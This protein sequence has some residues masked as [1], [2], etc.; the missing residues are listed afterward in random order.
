MH[1]NILDSPIQ[2][3]KGVGPKRGDLLKKELGIHTYYHLLTFFPFRYVDR[4]RIFTISELHSE[5]PLIQLKGKIISLAMLGKPRQKR[6]VAKFQ[7]E[8]GIIELVWFRGARWFEKLLNKNEEYLVFGK[9]NVYNGKLSMSHPEIDLL[10]EAD[11]AI[12]SPLQAVYSSTER[13]SSHGLNS[14]GIGKLMKELLTVSK[15]F[16][17][18]VLPIEMLQKNGL[19]PREESFEHVHI[20]GNSELLKKATYRLKF[21]ELFFI[22]LRILQSRQNRITSFKG[23]NFSQVGEHFNKFYKDVLPFELTKA[24]KRVIKEIRA[25]VGSGNQ[26]NR[27]LQGDVGS[28][29]TIVAFMVMLI[30]IDNGF[31]ACIMAPTAI[32]ANQHFVSIG[33]LAEKLELKIALLTGASTASVRKKLHEELE[34][35]DLHILI[36]THALIEDKV[37]FKNLGFV[38]IDEQHRFGVAQ[39][40]RLWK[41]NPISP[42]HILVM[43]ATPIPRT[44][45]MTLY[46]ELDVSIIDELP[47]GRM[48]VKTVHRFDK[49]RLSVFSFIK[50]QIKEGRQVYIVYPLIQESEK[51]D[52][53]DLMDGYESISR[54]FPR[55]EFQLCIV[56]GQMKPADKDFEMQRFVNGEAQIMVATNVIEVGV[57]IPNA[58]VMIIESAERFGLSQ[59]HQLRGR[60]GRGAKQSYCILMTG[61]K[62]SNDGKLRMNTLVRTNDGFEIA[63]VD[64]KLRGPGDLEGTQQSG[65]LDLKIADL[66]RDVQV[67]HQAREQASALLARDPNLATTESERVAKHLEDRYRHVKDWSR[68]S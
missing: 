13:L 22:Q 39:R 60:V 2:F 56:H 26:M 3:L 32:L 12:K 33:E 31:Q 49:S 62:L 52:Y 20:P 10:A 24:Q 46:G 37:K 29:K 5:I 59:L 15:G 28:G 51:M 44:L 47:P 36:G 30:A 34:A 27:L 63:D 35:G 19:L 8:T 50:E 67:L 55:P 61:A 65:I 18:E 43:T 16:L 25:D 23:L 1:H 57:N 4:S 6:L 9:A 45:A 11:A 53:K 64:L 40:A 21:E 58:S 54:A 14:R 7:D 66:V 42:P 17:P 68:I 41:K 48:P 38:V